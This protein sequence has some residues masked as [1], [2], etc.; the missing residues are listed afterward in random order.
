MHRAKAFL[1]VFRSHLK[2]LT[3][4]TAILFK[5][6]SPIYRPRRICGKQAVAITNVILS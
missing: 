6:A 1:T 2:R 3:V 4:K 5:V